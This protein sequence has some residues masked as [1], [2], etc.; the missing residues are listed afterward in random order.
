MA[1]EVGIEQGWRSEQAKGITLEGVV[2]KVL[3]GALRVAHK[4]RE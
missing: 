2:G 4:P 1:S 3:Q